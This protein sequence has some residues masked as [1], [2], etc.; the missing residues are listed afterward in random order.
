ME[1]PLIFPSE[2]LET[3]SPFQASE[4]DDSAHLLLRFDCLHDGSN[5][6]GI[7]ATAEIH[8]LVKPMLASREISRYGTKFLDAMVV[9]V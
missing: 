6:I 7:T 9:F 2:L 5:F 4:E 3:T 1:H 8:A